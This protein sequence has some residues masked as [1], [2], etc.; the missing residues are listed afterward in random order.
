M[1]VLHHKT[2]Q[3]YN[4]HYISH[5]SK[6]YNQLEVYK[7]NNNQKIVFSYQQTNLTHVKLPETI[8]NQ[9]RKSQKITLKL[10]QIC[11]KITKYQ[12]FLLIVL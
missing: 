2:N 6:W 8:S 3:F 12:R 4:N 9:V 5:N 1:K 7:L 10:I 11:K